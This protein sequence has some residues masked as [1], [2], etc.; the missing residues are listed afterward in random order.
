MVGGGGGGGG[1][2]FALALP[3]RVSLWWALEEEED[4][5]LPFRRECPCGGRLRA[6]LRLLG[7]PLRGQFQAS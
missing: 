1:G 4:S 3:P 2:G 5:P 6:V 7:V